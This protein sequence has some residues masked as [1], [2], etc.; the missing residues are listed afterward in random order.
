MPR[1]NTGPRTTAK[2]ARATGTSGTSGT[3]ATARSA[4]AKRAR[5]QDGPRGPHGRGEAAARLL[6]AHPDIKWVDAIYADL[7]GVVRGKRYPVAQLAKLLEGT[8]AMPGSVFLLDTAGESHDPCGYGFTDGDPDTPVRADPATL[9]PVPWAEVPSAQVL[10]RFY[11]KDGSPF[12]FE[13]RTVAGRALARLKEL[14]V[15]PV[16]AF[17][18]EFYLVDRERAAGGAPQPPASPATGRRGSET[19]VYAMTDVDA[20]GA[21]LQDIAEACAAQGIPCGAISSEYAP[22]QFEINLQHLEDPLLAADH[23]VLFK[24]AV[25][26]VARRHGLQAT[27]MAKPYADQAGS[28][29]HLHISLL[30]KAGRNLFDGGKEPASP[31]LRHAIG[32]V[33][34]LMPESMALLCPN[35]NSFRRFKPNIFTPL[36]RCW[37]YENR[38]VALR[39]PLGDGASRR[40]EHRIA[41]ADANPY[42]V[43][44]T[45]LA[46]VHRGLVEKIDPGP[47]FDGNAGADYD[48][49]VP[50]RPRRA[51]ERL[52]A[53]GPLVDY[54]GADYVKVYTACK[55]AELDSFESEIS[56]REYAWYLQAD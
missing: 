18:L 15:R 49:D 45:L 32:G 1:N 9:A 28:G 52:A 40:I 51:L 14:E 16:V 26:G 19:Q 17:E 39:V 8:L 25:K 30:D 42:L 48:P 11:E 44:A 43:L 41:G 55:L 4:R 37:G 31:A 12:R 5:G 3:S 46:G 10:L 6:A 2:G 54:L 20:Y 33:L 13:P 47:P 27:F 22:G 38:S 53:G 29:L 7:S 36:Q 21:V 24:R 23:A 56:D 34:D 50:F 35:V